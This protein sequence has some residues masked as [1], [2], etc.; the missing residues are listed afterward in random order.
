MSSETVPESFQGELILYTY[1]RSSCSA[2]VRTACQL[3]DIPLTYRFV[4]LVKGE[5]NE[6]PYV[7]DINPNGLVPTLL[8]NDASG[9]KITTI[10]Q[11]VAILEF[12]E[13]AVPTNR[14]LLPKDPLHRARVR[15]L[16]NIVACDTQPPTNLR[17][18]KKVNGYGVSNKDWF[19]QY[20]EKP[21]GAYE[22]ILQTTAGKYSVGDEVTLADVFLA[23]AIENALRWEVDMSKFTKVMRVFETIRELPEFKAADWRH[24][25]DTP[26]DLKAKD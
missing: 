22:K 1:F 5:Q 21:M 19:Q 9:N 26:D 2:R 16:V 10:S 11:S 12:L 17:I 13:E 7:D 15:E 4:N 8:V 14:S 24:Q 6:K 23:P 18:L 25:E 3:K 20:M